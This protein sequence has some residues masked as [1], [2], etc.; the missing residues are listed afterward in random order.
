VPQ[1]TEGE[2]PTQ[3]ASTVLV[4]EARARV[5]TFWTALA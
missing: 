3:S 5:S 1:A 4:A 2:G